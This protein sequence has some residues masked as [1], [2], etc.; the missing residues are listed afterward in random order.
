MTEKK[1]WG[2]RCPELI[3]SGTFI[4][5]YLGKILSNDEAVRALVPSVP[6]AQRS[7][8]MQTTVQDDSELVGPADVSMA[9]SR[10]IDAGKAEGRGC[11]PL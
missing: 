4:C 10:C 1:G 8:D 5:E 3:P 6:C 2:V 11:L 9:V 7:L